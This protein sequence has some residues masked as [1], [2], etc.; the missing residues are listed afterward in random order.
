[1]HPLSRCLVNSGIKKVSNGERKSSVTSTVREI[2]QRLATILIEKGG[3][4]KDI[5]PSA[6]FVFLNP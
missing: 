2:T 1:M 4:I 6:K 3:G 5:Q